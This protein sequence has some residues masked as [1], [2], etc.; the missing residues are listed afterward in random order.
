MKRKNDNPLPAGWQD[1]F[2]EK[3]DLDK[4]FASLGTKKHFYVEALRGHIRSLQ[5]RFE[6]AWDHFD[7]ASE[8]SEK[9]VEDIPNLIRQFL[10]HIWCFENA[11]AEA[12]LAE[13]EIEPPVLW[14]PPLPKE[15]LDDYPQVKLVINLRRMSEAVLRLHL[16]NWSESAEIYE[17][18]LRDNQGTRVDILAYV[19]SGL[20]ACQYNM[21]MED[22]ARRNL[23][24]AGF[25]ILSEGRTLERVR[26]AGTLYALY[27][28]I[29]DEEEANS[30]H[31]FLQ[32]LPCPQATKDVFLERGKVLIERCAERSRLL[33]I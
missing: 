18:L 6:E 30:W 1:E 20:A 33:V 16:G 11:L 19:Y 26:V 12:P 3:A 5:L 31:S 13:K 17:D 14:I 27:S 29:G 32:S 9:V 7:R 8:L 28:Q 21:G 15:I 24:N 22:A 4:S 10:L 25:A 23:E 2:A